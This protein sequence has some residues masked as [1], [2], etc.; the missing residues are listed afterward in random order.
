M[1]LAVLAVISPIVWQISNSLKSMGET[2]VG[3]P[4]SLI[5]E[6][7]T[8][9]NYIT[10]LTAIPLPQYFLNSV[11]ISAM[12]LMLTVVLATLTGYALARIRFRGRML[13]MTVL[14]A[15]T[16]LPFEVILVATLMITMELGLFN[17]FLGVV[18]PQGVSIIAIF[19]MRQA[20]VNIPNELEEA[21]RVDGAGA[22]R[23][24]WSVMLP[25]VTGSLAVVIVLGFLDSWDQFLWP[26]VVL[27]D[28]TMYP[29]T[30]GVQFLSGAFSADQR[31][32]AASSILVMIPPIL[33][34]FVM[35]RHVF[36]GLAG[37]A[38]KG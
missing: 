2:A 17:T 23:T 18:L 30:V 34:F 19:V 24:F 26:L 5:P 12:T 37:G 14:L 28:T 16:A 29:V 31:V 22:F 13:Y 38:L 27:S 10:A 7:P 20:F 4:G 3:F 35:Q 15:T 25:N 6:E 11:I 9:A 36:K 8:V 1:I 33:V 32:I 21:A